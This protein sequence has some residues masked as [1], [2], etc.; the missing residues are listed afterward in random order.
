MIYKIKKFAASL[1][2]VP[3]HLNKFR[4]AVQLLASF[5][6]LRSLIPLNYVNE[7]MP[8]SPAA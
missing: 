4:K 3:N 8:V 6:T 5:K 7:P 1:K 2:A